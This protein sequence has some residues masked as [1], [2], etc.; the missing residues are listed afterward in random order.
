[1]T[2]GHCGVGWHI[3]HNECDCD[4]YR[5]IGLFGNWDDANWGISK[6]LDGGEVF[7]ENSRKWIGAPKSGRECSGGGGKPDY[8]HGGAM[9][10]GMLPGHDVLGT[11]GSEVVS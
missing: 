2:E 1:M 3:W 8:G 11:C 5:S 10:S 7:L 4:A 6:G 9:G